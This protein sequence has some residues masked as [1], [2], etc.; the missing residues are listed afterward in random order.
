MKQTGVNVQFESE[1][2][3]ESMIT[4]GACFEQ[5]A[6]CCGKYGVHGAATR[7]AWRFSR[8][9]DFARLFC[10]QEL[11]VIR[12]KC[13][14]GE[15]DLRGDTLAHG[16]LFGVTRGFLSGVAFFLSLANHLIGRCPT[17]WRI[18]CA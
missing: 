13:D 3:P 12:K 17:N 5:L 15:G 11:H 2:G 1:L 14:G 4:R 10:L 6:A 18:H 16:L 9:G 7:L 8:T